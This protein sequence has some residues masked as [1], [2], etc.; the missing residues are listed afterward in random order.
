[1]FDNKLIPY[2]CEFFKAG[3]TAIIKMWLKNDCKE[4]PRDILE[5]IESEYNN[6]N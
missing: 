5:I 4:S 1:M 2:H 3:I 6:R